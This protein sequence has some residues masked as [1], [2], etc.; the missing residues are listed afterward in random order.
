M[1]N[2]LANRGGRADYR[3]GRGLFASETTGDAGLCVV[4]DVSVLD[5]L[6]RRICASGTIFLPDG[7]TPERSYLLQVGRDTAEKDGR[8][9]QDSRTNK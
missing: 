8:R 5:F 1:G 4:L 6:A 2:L 3:G 7:G 9:W